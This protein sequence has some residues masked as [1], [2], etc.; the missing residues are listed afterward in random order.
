VFFYKKDFFGHRAVIQ[1]HFLS[2]TFVY[3]NISF[4]GLPDK[5]QK[6]LSLMLDE[7]YNDGKGDSLHGVISDCNNNL[8][9]IE[10]SV[11]PSIIYRNNSSVI[12]KIAL[13]KID[14]QRLISLSDRKRHYEEWRSNL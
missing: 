12:R 4:L 2:D 1:F 14:E 5:H 7:K 9:W 3:C 8:V 6:K 13:E 10:R 11:Y